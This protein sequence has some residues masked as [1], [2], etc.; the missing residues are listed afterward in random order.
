MVIDRAWML[1]GGVI[2]AALAYASIKGARN[3][4]AGLGLAAVDMADGVLS[5]AVVG[6]G[7]KI[8]VPATD[9]DKCDAAIAAGDTW[10]AS[11]ACPAVKFVKY[12]SGA[13]TGG[14]SGSW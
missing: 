3:T 8:G 9:A 10:A 6:I 13:G 14:A 7:E 4:G 2:L 5:G 12:I 11:F 1:A